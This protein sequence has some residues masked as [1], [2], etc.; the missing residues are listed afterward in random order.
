MQLNGLSQTLLPEGRGV[1][2]A[3]GELSQTLGVS[4]FL[5]A[6]RSGYFP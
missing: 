4:E 5:C 6:R 1:C 2:W 3:L